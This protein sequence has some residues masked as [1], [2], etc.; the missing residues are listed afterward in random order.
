[1]T[2]DRTVDLRRSWPLFL[3]IFSLMLG[4]VILVQLL[5]FGAFLLMPPPAP[6]IYT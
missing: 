6:V 3:R 1:M 2:A 4:T 5:N